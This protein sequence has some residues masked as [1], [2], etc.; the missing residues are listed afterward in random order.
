[1]KLIAPVMSVQT[2]GMGPELLNGV[3]GH[4]WLGIRELGMNITWDP[5]GTPVRSKAHIIIALCISAHA[6]DPELSCPMGSQEAR[7]LV[8]DI[9]LGVNSVM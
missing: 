6:S 3:V 5:S 8:R 1:M 2:N 4:S 7:G 9:R